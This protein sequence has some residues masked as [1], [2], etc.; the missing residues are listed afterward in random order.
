[1]KHPLLRKLALHFAAK[2]RR[3]FAANKPRLHLTLYHVAAWYGCME[4]YGLWTT[5][6]V[7]Y[8]MLVKPFF[9]MWAEGNRILFGGKPNV[10][11]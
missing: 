10:K 2:A 3:K 11:P 6:Q 1:M 8:Y 5:V 7:G 4:L 9:R